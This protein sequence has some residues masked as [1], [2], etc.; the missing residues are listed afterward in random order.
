MK[1]SIEQFVK[2]GI[3]GV[4]NTCSSWVIYYPLVFLKVN[5]LIANTV[6][7]FGASIIGYFLNKIWV[8]KKKEKR[9]YKS[10][11]KYYFVYIS[12][13]FLQTLL[14]YIIVHKLKISDKIAPIITLMFTVP[15][16]FLLSKFWVFRNKMVDYEKLNNM[17]DMHSFAICAYKD[18]PYLEECIKSI[19][20]QTI[21]T[22]AYVCTSTPSKYIEGLAKKYQLPYYVKKTKSDIQDDWNFAYNKAKTELVTVAHQDDIY[23]DKYAETIL[24]NY[25]KNILMYNTDYNPYKNNKISTD[26]N[27]KIKRLLKVFTKSKLLCHFKFIKVSSL[28]FGNSINC[29]SVAYNKKKLGKSIF[30]SDL[31]FSLDWDTFLKIARMK[32]GSLYIPKKLINYRIHEEATTKDFIISHKREEEDITMFNKIWPSFITKII[33]KVYTKSYDTYD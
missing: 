11:I 24:L 27:S 23:N 28:A 31:K 1:K 29:P 17:K 26:K 4:I 18:S 21:F 8:F 7:Y 12:C 15:Y 32:G 19:V 14:M 2:F 6:A 33:M 20:N 22:N 16:N 13:F 3:V 30:T 9:I 10:I 25:N 5:Y